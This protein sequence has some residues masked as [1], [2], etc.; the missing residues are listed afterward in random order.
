MRG[1][2]AEASDG[3]T[4]TKASPPRSGDWSPGRADVDTKAPSPPAKRGRGPG[5]GGHH[6]HASIR[7]DD[8]VGADAG[9]VEQL[10]G[11][12]EPGISRTASA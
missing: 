11:V 9:G 7:R 3:A 1:G 4:M 2:P 12:P 8:G 6:R 5:R 10:A